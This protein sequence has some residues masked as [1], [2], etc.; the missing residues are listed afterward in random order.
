MTLPERRPTAVSGSD[1]G[2]RQQ[3]RFPAAAD[4][5]FR[6][7][8]RSRS[9]P[10]QFFRKLHTVPHAGAELFKKSL[11]DLKGEADGVA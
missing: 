2:F 6:Q 10:L 8:P 9:N 11:V 4:R 1:R 7:R 3:P 5:G